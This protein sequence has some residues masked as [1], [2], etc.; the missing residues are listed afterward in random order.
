MGKTS[1]VSVST[2]AVVV[3]LARVVL[4]TVVSAAA[5]TLAMS[6]VGTWSVRVLGVGVEVVAERRERGGMIIG[7]ST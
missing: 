1:L 3:L 6:S 4:A 5:G 2:C 7:T